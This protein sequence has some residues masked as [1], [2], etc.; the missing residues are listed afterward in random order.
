MTSVQG[1]WW[2][3]QNLKRLVGG[4]AA[5]G[6]AAM[7]QAAMRTRGCKEDFVPNPELLQEGKVRPHCPGPTLMQR[8]ACPQ[9]ALSVVVLPWPC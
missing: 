2:V 6:E 7:L 3:F 4:Q 1:C 8:R 5:E 9:T